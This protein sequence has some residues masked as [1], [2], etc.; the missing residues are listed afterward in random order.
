MPPINTNASPIEISEWKKKP[1]VENCYK[2]LFINSNNKEEEPL[3]L[4]RIV[5]R[6]FKKKCSTN[7]M[8]F[9]VAVCSYVLNPKY[10]NL[11]LKEKTI[12]RKVKIYSVSF[13]IFLY[14]KLVMIS[15]FVNIIHFFK[16]KIEAKMP[17][18]DEETGDENENVSESE[19]ESEDED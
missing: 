15:L 8:S 1:E 16:K 11:K 3:I 13:I 6:V 10:Q 18:L 7:E 2:K 17:L 19:S 12:K 4:T 5:Q 14:S 9:V